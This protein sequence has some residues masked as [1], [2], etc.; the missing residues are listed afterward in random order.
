MC[1]IPSAA[2]MSSRIWQKTK[3]FFKEFNNASPAGIRY[4]DGTANAVEIVIHHSAHVLV[5]FHLFFL[6]RVVACEDVLYN[7]LSAFV[8]PNREQ[9]GKEFQSF[10]KLT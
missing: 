8:N 2:G 4:V 5:H 3:V 10:S 9:F 6:A 7:I 1:I